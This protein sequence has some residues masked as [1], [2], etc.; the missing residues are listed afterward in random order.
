MKPSIFEVLNWVFSWVSSWILSWIV[1]KDPKL[2]LVSGRQFG[3]NTKPI[4][5]EAE[6]F[7]LNAVW[8]TNRVEVLKINDKKIVSAYSLKGLWYGARASKVVFTHTVGDFEPLVFPSSR[9]EYY[10]VW[11]GMPMRKISTMDPDFWK[12]KHAKSNVREMKRYTGMFVS[13]SMMQDI[14]HKTFG[15]KLEKI[16]VTGQP[17]TDDLVRGNDFCFDHLYDPPLP[18]G[19][20]KILY[21]PTWREGKPVTLFPFPDKN[22][23][24]LQSKL[25]ELNAV[26]YVRTHPN[27]P[28]RWLKREK[29]IV[30]FQG[31]IAPEVTDALSRFDVLIT[32]Y[33]S[34]FYD[35]LLLNRPTIFFSYD[36][37]DY[38]RSPGFYMPYK[39]ITAGPHPKTQREFVGELKLFLN[40]TDNYSGDRK[41]IYDK[42]YT[43]SDD[44][45]TSRVLSIM[46]NNVLLKQ[47]KT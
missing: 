15:I 8:I 46:K 21:C 4:L 13:S 30:P 6:S 38:S 3:G 39:E 19:H 9:V 7:G 1:P 29:R 14:F 32:D 28:G 35:F 33:S 5:L 20:R 23:E 26:I 17:R 41:K 24:E 45:A 12:R 47:D 31:D 40:K 43:Y 22:I 11:H 42:M 18:V 44:L 36:L 37:D 34:V 27:D 2:L 25:E 10:N 16:Y